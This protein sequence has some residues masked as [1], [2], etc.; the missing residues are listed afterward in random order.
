[1]YWKVLGTIYEVAI[2][3]CETRA[4]GQ[5]DDRLRDCAPRLRTGWLLSSTRDHPAAD[6]EATA[7]DHPA[8]CRRAAGQSE[9]FRPVVDDPGIFVEGAEWRRV[10]LVR[11]DARESPAR[12]DLPARFCVPRDQVQ[13]AVR[14]PYLSE[15][16]RP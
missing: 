3:T 14:E 9:P 2:V 16:R 8:C 12:L 1:M 15:R 11:R 5:V 10:L 13:E 4:A 6:A 7:C